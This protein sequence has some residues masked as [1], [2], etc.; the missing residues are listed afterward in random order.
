MG[1]WKIDRLYRNIPTYCRLSLQVTSTVNTHIHLLD[2]P[3][4]TFLTLF[5]YY[6]TLTHSCIY[7]R[8]DAINYTLTNANEIYHLTYSYNQTM[9]SFLIHNCRFLFI[10]ALCVIHNKNVSFVD[11]KNYTCAFIILST[12]TK[13]VA[14]KITF[15]SFLSQINDD[16][17]FFFFGCC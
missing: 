8:T 5:L 12:Y 13:M 3:V 16:W 11:R 15:C 9:T 2:A 7:V 14:Q 17:F 6:T 10:S 1:K 4:L